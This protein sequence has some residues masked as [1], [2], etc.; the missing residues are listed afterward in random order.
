VTSSLLFTTSSSGEKQRKSYKMGPGFG[1]QK[2]QP[3]PE[4]SDEGWYRRRKLKYFEMPNVAVILI[5]AW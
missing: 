1:S 3:K 5:Y 2:L 4:V